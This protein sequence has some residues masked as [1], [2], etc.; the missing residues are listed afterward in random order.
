MQNIYNESI[1]K[2]ANGAKF[3]VD[4]QTRSLKID[5]K[6][7]IKNGE[8]DGELGVGLTT[9]PLLIITQLFL[10][11]QH[12]LPSERSDNKRKKYFI[13]LPEHELSDED[14]LY[15]EP[16]E[17]AQISLELY[18]LGVILNGSLQWDKFAKDKWFWQSP[19]VKELVILK[20]WIE[21]TTNK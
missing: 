21:P 15:G 11:Y 5:G 6:Y 10:R 3:Q 18:V 16:R 13:A 14:M 4:F 17:T 9:N 2:V 12:S 19:N 20:E 7:I 1:E 8:Y